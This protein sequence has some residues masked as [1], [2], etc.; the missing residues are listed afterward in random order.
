MVFCS[1][2][3]TPAGGYDGDI[4]YQRLAA[5]GSPAG[6]PVMVSTDDATDDKFADVSGN[7]IV[8]TAFA[9]PTS[10]LGQLKVY[11]VS[12]G[13][14]VTLD[15][16][17]ST[18]REARIDGTVIVW[19]QG[20]SGTTEVW[21]LD[22]TSV[23]GTAY[24]LRGPNPA[25]S[26]VEIGSRYVVWEETNGTQ[27]D[28][29]AYDR[30]TGTYITVSAD[31]GLDDRLPTTWGNW[32]AWQTEDSAGARAI[33]LANLAVKPVA[34]FVAVDDGFNVGRPSVDEGLVAFESDASGNLDVYVYRIADARIFRITYDG[35]EQ[36]LNSL[37]GDVVGYVDL[38]GDSLDIYV[39]RFRLPPVE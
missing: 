33:R 27:K 22:L 28:I 20:Q 18:V 5:D 17:S 16:P 8:Y 26:N 14:T 19:T 9:S 12:S 34:P 31:P 21:Y 4:L 35:E 2:A 30:L 39:S 6:L 24:L 32:V 36:F 37:L 10:V 7:R 29:T 1:Q 3:L 38:R 23:A 15:Q 13:A 11:D 25:A